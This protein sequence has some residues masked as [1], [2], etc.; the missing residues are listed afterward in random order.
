MLDFETVAKTMKIWRSDDRVV[1]QLENNIDTISNRP[2]MLL[3]KIQFGKTRVFVGIIARAFDR[4]FDSV[5][6]MKTNL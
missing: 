5:K 2:S 3:G 1:K 6:G 4:G